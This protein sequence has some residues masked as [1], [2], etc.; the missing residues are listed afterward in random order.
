MHILLVDDE[1]ENRVALAEVLRAEGYSVDTAS[2]GLEALELI[3]NLEFD[4]VVT[5]ALMPRMDG[6]VL[7]RTVKADEAH[8]DLPVIILTGEYTNSLDI[9]F[10]KNL[11]AIDVLR[12]TADPDLLLR[13][14]S[15]FKEPSTAPGVPV[16]KEI[17]E[18]EY[19]KEYSEVLVRK[20]EAKM[21]ELEAVNQKL[22][23]RNVQLERER[24]KYRQL[25]ISAN[26]GILLVNRS[27]GIVIES[28]IHAR[29]I[30]KLSE[31]GLS[32]KPLIELK[33]FGE[34]LFEKISRGEAVQFES[35]YENEKSKIFL[36]ISGSSTGTEDNLYI[37]IIR[38][39]T[40]RREWLERFIMLDKLRA[41]GRLSSGLVHEIGNPLNVISVNLQFLDKSLDE[42]LPEKNFTKSALSGVKSIEKV[43]R[44]TMNFAQP[45]APAK[46][47]LRL[48]SLLSEISGLAKTSLQK[49]KISLEIEQS[50]TNDTI[51]ADKSQLLHAILNIVEN[52]IEAMPNGGK[53]LFRLED[54]ADVNELVLKIV[55]T[56]VGMDE[57]TVKLAVEPFYT[58]KD[59]ATG[60][61]L[62]ISHRLLEL[63]DASLSI[64]SQ[65]GFGTTV[66]IRFR[67]ENQ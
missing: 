59:G 35:T 63:N 26:D 24:R 47:K 11:G 56:G 43:M 51:A 13:L 23:E 28:N 54:C 10:A 52:S 33:P 4:A 6:F 53:L 45:Q 16:H 39:V 22:V 19:L 36:D 25:F 55:D 38:N 65:P 50:E 64:E 7:C 30:L 57:D 17:P 49:S 48:G 27:D 41:V 31:K 29:K 14:L 37:V 32:Q 46:T 5:D 34:L 67:R 62:S 58:T 42:K 40:R 15:T 60:M 3:K 12:K 21:A 66:T 18:K 44:E 2:D 1:V 61:G 20:L 9:Q 8:K